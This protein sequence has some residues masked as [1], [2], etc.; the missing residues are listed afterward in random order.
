MFVIEDLLTNPVRD[1]LRQAQS[2]L[3]LSNKYG[4]V[5][6]EKACQRA[7]A[8]SAGNLKTIKTILQEGL[9][10]KPIKTEETFEK[11]S[12]VYQGKGKFQRQSN[13]LLH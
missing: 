4:D 8:F 13:D 1:L 10:A 11:L 9:D 12:A 6:L 7:C 2:I 3:K 5:R